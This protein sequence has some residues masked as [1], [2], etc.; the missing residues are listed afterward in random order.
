[1]DSCFTPAF[2]FNIYTAPRGGY[3]FFIFYFII[4]IILLLIFAR[5][6][7]EAWSS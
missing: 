1:M 3:Y 5:E 2:S 7:I 4:I 6:A